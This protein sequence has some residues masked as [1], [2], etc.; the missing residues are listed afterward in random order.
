V[1]EELGADVNQAKELGFSPLCHAAMRGQLGIVRCLL[2][3]RADIDHAN[4]T[5]QTPL[6]LASCANHAEV[7]KWLNCEGRCQTWSQHD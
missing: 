4:I 3:L 5:G 7:V 2:R 6:M 1:L